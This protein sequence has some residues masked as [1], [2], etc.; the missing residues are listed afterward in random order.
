MFSFK[1]V[2]YRIKPLTKHLFGRTEVKGY[3]FSQIRQLD[4]A[5]IYEVSH[6]GSNKHYEVFKRII[7]RR[8]VCVSYPSSKAFGKWAHRYMSLE[9]AKLKFN[10]LNHR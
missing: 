3:L 2:F 6:H 4:R 1:K 7:N 5:F 9:K 10:N 8:Y